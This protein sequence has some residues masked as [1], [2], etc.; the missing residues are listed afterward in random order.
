[1]TMNRDGQVQRPII[2]LM[3]RINRI[4]YRPLVSS[5]LQKS[6]IALA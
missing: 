3:D 4:E 2:T 5:I 1:M 6:L